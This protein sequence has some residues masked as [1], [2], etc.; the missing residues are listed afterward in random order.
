MGRR[1]CGARRAGSIGGAERSVAGDRACD[2]RRARRADER[3]ELRW[4]TGGASLTD[5]R[6]APS[7]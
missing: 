3:D 2:T 4:R 6:P 5:E 7:R 1:H